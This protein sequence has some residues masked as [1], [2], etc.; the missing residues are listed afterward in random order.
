MTQQLPSLQYP[1]GEM[2]ANVLMVGNPGDKLAVVGPVLKIN[3]PLA[4]DSQ[5]YLTIYSITW[6]SPP[7]WAGR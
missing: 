2:N 5:W 4:E 7:G 3:G 1:S 6:I